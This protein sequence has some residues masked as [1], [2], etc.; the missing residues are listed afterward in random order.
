MAAESD[1]NVYSDG[2]F[3]CECS[4]SRVLAPQ[5]CSGQVLNRVTLFHW[6]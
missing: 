1:Y 3:E 4:M 6:Q 5:G 2:F